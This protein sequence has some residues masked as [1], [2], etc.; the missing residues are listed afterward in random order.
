[1]K[2][3]D[4]KLR[5][6]CLTHGFKRSAMCIL[7]LTK[8]LNRKLYIVVIAERDSDGETIGITGFVDIFK[9]HSKAVDLVRMDP[10]KYDIVNESGRLV[11]Y[12]C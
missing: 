10:E 7:A 11:S 3:E 8:L 1:M 2:C 4:C 6:D 5:V 9:E 12:R